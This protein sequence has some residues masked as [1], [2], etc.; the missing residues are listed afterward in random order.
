M[1]AAYSRFYRFDFY[2]KTSSTPAPVAQYSPPVVPPPVVRQSPPP[3]VLR[4]P[5]PRASGSS[6][7]DHGSAPS[8][9]G[10]GL[11]A[12]CEAAIIKD[13]LGSLGSL[14]SGSR[15]ASLSDSTCET[16]ITKD[17]Q[18]PTAAGTA[19]PTTA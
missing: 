8:A 18:C 2:Y 14:M 12:E 11:G 17:N 5:P 16:C 13:L 6:S 9:F 15:S 19:S 1:T 7:S 3:P 4:P 10:N